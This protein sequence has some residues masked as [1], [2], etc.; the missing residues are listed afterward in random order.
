MFGSTKRAI[1]PFSRTATTSRSKQRSSLRARKRPKT[2]APL[3]ALENRQLLATLT[4]VGDVNGSWNTNVA[5]N[6]NWSGDV[7]PSNGD[8]LVFP[9]V[10]S[11]KTQTNN[12]TAGSTFYLS[13]TGNGYTI[14]GNSIA[15]T[16]NAITTSVTSGVNSL[17]TPLI[18][19]AATT[20]NIGNTGHRLELGG[21][22]SGGANDLIKTGPGVLRFDGA[23][24]N[25]YTGTTFVNEGTLQLDRSSFNTAIR[26]PLVVG[27]GAGGSALVDG[28]QVAQIQNNQPI[29]VNSDG[30]FRTVGEIFGDL[31]VNDGR[32]TANSGGAD[33]TSLTMSGGLIDGNSSLTLRGD[34]V[35]TNSGLQ[36]VITADVILGVPQ[37][38][39]DVAASVVGPIPDLLISGDI[40]GNA[41]ISKSGTGW[42]ELSGTNTYT[43]PSQVFAGRF[44][45]NGS[46]TSD[47]YISGG[48]LNGN[49]SV[50]DVFSTAQGGL[51]SAG[52]SP[53]TLLTGDLVLD[54]TVAFLEEIIGPIPGFQYDQI[55]VTGIV[56]ISNSVLV[57]DQLSTYVPPPGAVFT[58]IQN[59]GADL[60][61]GHFAG[62]PDGAAFTVNG[63]TIYRVFYNG[64]DGND[65]VLVA[66]GV[67]IALPDN[68]VG[69]E[70]TP[71]VVPPLFGPPPFGVLA[72]DYD[73]NGDPLQAVLISGPVR[74]DGGPTGTL[75]LNSDGSFTFVP[76]QDMHSD[77]L[78]PATWV[79]FVYAAWDGIDYSTI[80]NPELDPFFPFPT[81][82]VTTVTIIINSV[83]QSPE[84]RPDFY[85]TNEDTPLVVGAPGVL[86]N[87]N[88]PNFPVLPPD[89]V[90]TAQIIVNPSNA[91]SFTLNPDG[92]FNYTP[93]ANW[94]GTD[95]FTYVVVVDSL[96]PTLNGL[97]SGATV[98]TITVLPVPD[99]PTV[100]DDLFFTTQNLPI[101]VG[102]PGI[103]ANDVNPE[104][105]LSD[106]QAILVGGPQFGNLVLNGDG[107]FVYTPFENFT[108]FDTF[109]YLAYNGALSDPLFPATVTIFVLP[110]PKPIAVADTYSTLENIPLSVGPAGVLTNDSIPF[111][112]GSAVLVFGPMHSSAFVFNGDGSFDYTPT[113]GFDGVDEFYYYAVDDATGLASIPIRVTIN[114]VNVNTIPIANPDT[115]TTTVKASIGVAAPG[116]LAN[117]FDADGDLLT[118]LLVSQ[119]Q[120]GFVIL[121][122]DGSFVYFPNFNLASPPAFDTFTYQVFDGLN[123]SLA[124]T[125]TINLIPDT[126]P[127]AN[128]DSYSL[129]E[130]TVLEVGPSGVLANDTDADGDPLTAIL[131]TGPTH[132]TVFLRPDGSFAYVP[133]ANY[134]GPDSFTYWAFDGLL[135]SNFTTVTLNVTS[136]ADAPT[137]INHTYAVMENAPA[138][139][140]SLVVAA[141]GVFLGSTNPDGNPLTVVVVNG[142]LHSSGAGGSFAINT[143]TGAFTY[144]PNNFF[145]GSD[146]F[147]YYLHDPLSGLDS[148]LATVTLVVLP[149]NDAPTVLTPQAFSTNEDTPLIVAAPGVLIGATDPDGDVLSAVLINGPS[150]GSLVLNGNGSFIYT[151][152]S[153]YNGP[154]SFTFRAWDGQLFSNLGTVNITV[155]PVPDAPIAVDDVYSVAEDTLLTIVAPG[156]LG[157]DINP[158]VGVLTAILVNGPIYAVPGLGGTFSFNADGSFTYRANTNFYGTDTFTYRAFNGLLSN[159]ATV[160]IHVL[161]V[162]DTPVAVD[163]VYTIGEDHTLVVSFPGVLI[164]DSDA[165]GDVLYASLLTGPLHGSMTLNSNGSFVYIPDAN[166]NGIEVMTYRAWDGGYLLG[167]ASNIATITINVTALPDLPIANND[168]YTLLEDTTLT[169]AS[170]GILLNDINPDSLLPAA[171]YAGL[172]P[173]IVNGPLH[174]SLTANANGSFVYTPVTNYFGSD[175][176]TYY[177]T[178]AAGTSLTATVSLTI[179]NVPDR[180]LANND[181]FQTMEDVPLIVG[182]PGVLFN[183]N[184][185]DDFVGPA[186]PLGGFNGLH[187]VLINNASNGTVLLNADGSFIYTPNA[188]FF[189]SDSF[190]Y[191]VVNAAGLADLTPATVTIN[192]LSV[193]D[194]PVARD[195]FYTIDEDS[196]LTVPAPGILGNDYDPDNLN[197]NLPYFGLT[198]ILVNTTQKGTLTL[199]PNG[200]FVYTPFP[201]V[202]GVDVDSFTYIV[203]DSTGLYSNVARV[204]IA[205]VE[206][207]ETTVFLAAS[208]DTGC[209][210]TDRITKDNT[211]TFYGVT[212]P[213]TTVVLTARLEGSLV[214]QIVGTTFADSTGYYSVTSTALP[215]GQY[216][217][218][219][220]GFRPPPPGNPVQST[221][222]VNAGN[223]LIDTVAPVVTGA[224]LVPRS[225]QVYVGFQDELSGMCVPTMANIGNY[226]FS[227]LHNANPRSLAISNAQVQPAATPTSEQ[228][229]VLRIAKKHKISQGRYLFA[230]IS[231]GIADKAGNALDG[232]FNGSYPSGDG[233]P[234]GNFLSQFN[235]GHGLNP[236]VA[237]PTSSFVPIL[238]Q[239]PSAPTLGGVMPGGPASLLKKVKAKK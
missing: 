167:S 37:V 122:G 139:P 55:V 90:L 19:S 196:T 138:H 213:F 102:A 148:N 67:P 4:W 207:P 198:A 217:F 48:A 31:I 179:V 80:L 92:S 81:L 16:G 168:S 197:V 147:T 51:I 1:N 11:N 199:N 132:G 190:T 76:A 10:A 227:R 202:S 200:S 77:P 121:N 174:G 61:L 166:W 189:G 47:V 146:F 2:L 112:P 103:L 127:V 14:G 186:D 152:Y 26:G 113:T 142:P 191:T 87:D 118:A 143:A 215:D 119:A 239:P 25:T 109:T 7:L 187:A 219:V 101:F 185:P 226:S 150:F 181:T 233:S 123:V 106:L 68:Y 159:I 34:V 20:I 70:N 145:F 13:F 137:A 82:S 195:N 107:S 97:T 164:N 208:S 35:T 176:F 50:G 222:I 73:F 12:T 204:V 157:N 27:D 57:V 66:N 53:G 63:T 165:D 36:S 156:V 216:T 38:D 201:G 177:V 84:G 182:A 225:S 234:G 171:P 136:V 169:I 153:N 163:D 93:Q 111:G 237:V 124:A 223:L 154:D 211:P 238:T 105:P 140:N 116:V 29:T 126:A 110:N 144:T 45:V 23:A 96:D 94:F 69:V 79:T 178:S 5:G 56:N 228:I 214:S 40:T 194:A 86:V 33:T 54:S 206:T 125:V 99:A 173:T 95:T 46:I 220:E 232:E 108:G 30:R 114:V 235:V 155:F 130:D 59:D 205:I 131:R 75:T 128:P 183:D 158:D 9:A 42:L 104:G 21:V 71:L 6:T 151:P 17:D 135:L 22:I 134:F 64:G 180:P 175:F 229:V 193:P 91:A 192:V 8:T 209:S 100:V 120:Y 28:L 65:V 161:P 60:T 129:A 188:N 224:V 89:T 18:L 115:Y 162:N 74:A 230:I 15:L 149:V 88:L 172:T 72:N 3:E 49:G 85:T 43:G 41:S 170:P 98:V 83:N 32:V 62:L 218:F 210:P 141:P 212:V 203:Q 24:N 133:F 236:V 44:I 52:N 117:D 184:N 221:G 160:T 231:G 58:L 39:F 78:D